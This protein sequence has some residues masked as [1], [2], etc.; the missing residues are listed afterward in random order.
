MGRMDA[1]LF[2][3]PAQLMAVI[4]KKDQIDCKFY[5]AK[6][7]CKFW[8]KMGSIRA[9]FFEAE[10]WANRSKPTQVVVNLVNK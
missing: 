1:T 10:I 6:K 7:D 8:K 3:H 9:T 5:R 4:Q 2:V